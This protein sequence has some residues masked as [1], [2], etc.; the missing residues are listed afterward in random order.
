MNL[1]RNYSKK[2][3]G[4]EEPKPIEQDPER[5]KHKTIS[6]V[7]L[8]NQEDIDALRWPEDLRVG[9]YVAYK[10]G[11]Q[12]P[13]LVC[14]TEDVEFYRHGPDQ[15]RFATQRE[16]LAHHHKD[17]DRVYLY[18]IWAYNYARVIYHLTD[19]PNERKANRHRSDI[20]SD[21]SPKL[22]RD[23]PS[24]SLGIGSWLNYEDR[25]GNRSSYRVV[26]LGDGGCFL[27]V[28]GASVW[29]D[30]SRIELNS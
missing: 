5:P 27:S 13:S 29:I 1:L 6:L 22:V 15:H 10:T 30:Y 25:N 14:D 12:P 20:A 28:L 11:N 19:I 9:M 26:S 24:K 16:V 17:A 3:F 7:S 18:E 4:G 8:W 2:A 23:D 21:Y